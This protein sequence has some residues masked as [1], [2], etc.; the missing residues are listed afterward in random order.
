MTPSQKQAVCAKC[1]TVDEL[2]LGY[3]F[4]CALQGEL[5]AAKRTAWQHFVNGLGKIHEPKRWWQVRY[6][7]SWA[8]QR[9]TRTGDYAEDGTFD[10]EGYDW[11]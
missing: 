10:R 4:E 6:D 11:R 3:C 5:R 2:R 1:G 7:W 8:W 9:M